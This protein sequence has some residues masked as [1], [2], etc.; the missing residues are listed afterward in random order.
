MLASTEQLSIAFFGIVKQF[1]WRKV[2]IV[3]QNE[4]VFI[5]VSFMQ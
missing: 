3:E 4:N 2:A 5:V 1:Q